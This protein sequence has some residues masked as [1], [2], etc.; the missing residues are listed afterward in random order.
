[1]SKKL[2]LADDSITIQ[3]VIGITFA[4][5]DY[6]LSVVDNGDAALEKARSMTPDLILADVFMP[7][8]NGYELC[9]AVRQ[10]P[11][12]QKIPVLLLT[13]TFEPFDE[14]K[15]RS[16]G[17]DSWIAKPFE[18]QALIDR[19]EELLAKRQQPVPVVAA[20]TVATAVA[21]APALTSVLPPHLVAA[22]APDADIWGDLAD[23]DGAGAGQ[24]PVGGPSFAETSAATVEIATTADALPSDED[25]WGDVSFDEEDLLASEPA[26]EAAEDIWGIME[27]DSAVAA[28]PVAFADESFALS[29]EEESLLGETPQAVSVAPPSV[30][31]FIFDEEEE[32][33]SPMSAGGQELL[34]E[35]I[36]PLEELEILEEED[37]DAVAAA[38]DGESFHFAEESEPFVAATPVA[39]EVAG[40]VQA[41]AA[42]AP[43][44]ELPIAFD[45]QFDLVEE[46]PEWGAAEEP[47]VG[48]ETLAPAVEDYLIT[49]AAAAQAAGS[50]APPMAVAVAEERVRAL[51][52]EEL[53]QIVERVAGS[54]IERLAGS[55]LEKIVWEVVPDLAESLVK[56]EIRKI[57][58]EA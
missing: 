17:A 32:F 52:E 48:I 22:T 30:D 13:G 24:T 39:A 42:G 38:P 43:A 45:D 41:L 26:G 2:L 46:G 6:E 12:L 8:M 49:S 53:A 47:A 40:E 58:Q 19:V 20:A 10:D 34:E 57:R 56:E 37:L 1:M 27:E 33:A 7:G 14:N 55:V 18:S 3:K 9:A 50:V 15:A 51:S 31:E 54:V 25:I 4:N 21:E 16:V 36:L 29:G 28:P 44:G 35:D 11:L 23:A 5:E